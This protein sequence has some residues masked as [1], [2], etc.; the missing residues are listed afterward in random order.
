MF[1]HVAM[2]RFAAGTTSEQVDEI[3]AALAEMRREIDVLTTYRHGR[4]AGITDGAWDYA[5]VAGLDHAEDY[6]AYRDHPRHREI[7]E[8]LI[9]PLIVEAARIQFED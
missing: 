4:D 6:P 9:R 5:V 2:F 7:V 3:D 1:F 8:S